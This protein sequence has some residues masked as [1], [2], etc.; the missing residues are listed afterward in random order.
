MSINQSLLN[1][2]GQWSGPNRLWLEPGTPVRISDT[3]AAIRLAAGERFLVI[4]YT[5]ADEGKPQD[6][7]LMVDIEDDE[8]PRAA[9]WIDSWHL[10]GAI[11]QF[12]VESAGDGILALHGS[13]PASEG[14][15]WGWRIEI[16]P[17][18]TD[19]FDLRMFNITPDGQEMLAVQ[20][21]YSRKV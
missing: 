19:R 21:E 5:W 12:K 13:Y 17:Q 15:D 11:M 1:L 3:T 20:A 9:S 8:T 18:S 14:P 7:L 2:P 10:T 6:G 16:H 4:Q